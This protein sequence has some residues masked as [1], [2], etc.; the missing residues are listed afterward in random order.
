MTLNTSTNDIE[1][2]NQCVEIILKITEYTAYQYDYYKPHIEE[3]FQQCPEVKKYIKKWSTSSENRHLPRSL[4][5]ALRKELGDKYGDT[6]ELLYQR[7]TVY[8]KK[9]VWYRQIESSIGSILKKMSTIGYL[10]FFA[11]VLLVSPIFI[12][13]FCKPQIDVWAERLYSAIGGNWI[14][15]NFG[16]MLVLGVLA[17]LL[18]CVYIRLYIYKENVLIRYIIVAVM[19][20]LVFIL[21]GYPFSKMVMFVLAVVLEVWG[22]MRLKTA[23]NK[24]PKKTTSTPSD[25]QNT[26]LRKFLANAVKEAPKEIWKWNTEQRI[27]LVILVTV[28]FLLV[29][30]MLSPVTMKKTVKQPPVDVN[31]IYPSWL[32]YGDKGKITFEPVSSPTITHAVT[33]TVMLEPEQGINNMI[34]MKPEENTNCTPACTFQIM[35]SITSTKVFQWE[36]LTPPLTSFVNDD[37]NWQVRLQYT[38][39]LSNPQQSV[40]DDFI[41]I[42]IPRLKIGFGIWSFFHNRTL[43]GIFTIIFSIAFAMMQ[44][45]LVQKIDSTPSEKN[46]IPPETT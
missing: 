43:T 10:V 26:R 5:D 38:Q 28:G 34:I 12:I 1:N 8:L 11:F 45:W 3:L 36:L 9:N 27:I 46:K 4:E 2:I 33:M 29:S 32:S 25:E 37:E 13:T 21:I 30:Y 18:F 23:F 15:S 40:Y 17:A 41:S 19:V 22:L 7:T 20:F 6:L 42:S 24:I 31:I 44:I 35:P 16:V 14:Q 39:P